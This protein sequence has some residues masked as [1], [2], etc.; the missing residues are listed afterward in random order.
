VRPL[1]VIDLRDTYE[2][3]GPGKTILETFRAID[4]SSF[5]LHLGVFARQ[6]ESAETP[7][8]SAA[9]E[10]GM[11]VHVLRS[12]SQYDPR[13]VSRLA[14][15]IEELEIDL[16][17]AHEVKSD[18]LT[19]L[20]SFIRPVPILT[21]LH[22]WIGNS[23]KQRLLIGVDK[24]IA[25]RYDRV[26]AVSEKMRQELHDAG[27]P[28]ERVVLVHN[29]IVLENYRRTGQR[30]F[31]AEV[32]GRAVPGPVVV[33]IGR[34]SHEK[35]HAD[36]IE[37]LGQ[38]ASRGC[39]MTAVLAGDGP[40]R[41]ALERQIARLGLQDSVHLPGYID[42]PQRLLEDAD[43]SVLPSHTEGLPNAALEALAMEVPVLATR[44]GGT[45][46]VITDGETG[47]LV[48][49]KAPEA[50]AAALMDFAADPAPWRRMAERG[51]TMVV[52][53]F[54]FRARTRRMEDLY[55]EMTGRQPAGTSAAGH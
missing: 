20:A 37:A 8:V 24:L 25:R 7:F 34:L 54:D 13:L 33:S 31:L 39:R 22:G 46:D 5:R 30:G 3:G 19:Y 48:E 29:A 50:L 18:V 32:V 9:R 12:S 2:V 45:P 44:V 28:P 21:T 1:N 27:V 42:R 10:Y 16:V 36:L 43:L 26:I 6:D 49:A 35:G 40:E 17:H 23:P 11:P 52:S 4:A 53:R 41:P 38:A 51:R 15:L 14:R 47:R 55:L